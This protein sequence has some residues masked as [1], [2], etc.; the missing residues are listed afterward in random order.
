[1]KPSDFIKEAANP[2]QQAAIAIAMKKAGKK[3][4]NEATMK[5]A[6]KEPMGPQFTGYFKGTDKPPVGKKL[7]GGESTQ[8]AE[9]WNP[10]ATVKREPLKNYKEI[11]TWLGVDHNM[12]K[13]L[14]MRFPGFPSPVP[15]VRASHGSHE[16]YQPSKIKDWVRANNILDVIA[17]IKSKQQ[18]KVSTQENIQAGDQ[19]RT[20]KMS[21]RGIVESVELYRPFGELAVYF[22]TA[23]DQLL[24]TPMSN[25]IKIPKGE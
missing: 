23:D 8:G 15:G 14:R 18:P 16:Y 9:K 20:R 7:V 22:R 10:R 24:R 6:E 17:Q 19:I 25:V 1:M 21:H 11:T 3:P 5:S 12:L 2:A 13:G 4:K